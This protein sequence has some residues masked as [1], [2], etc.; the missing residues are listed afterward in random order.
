MIFDTSFI[1][2][3]MRRDENALK[4]FREVLSGDQ[5]QIITTPTLFEL[6]SG[7]AQSDK[8]YSEKE[9]IIYT[10]SHLITWHLD[11]KSAE[12]GGEIHGKLTKEGQMIDSIDSMIAGI[13]LIS[14]ERVLTRNTKHFSKIAGLKTETY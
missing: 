10:I 7:L 11:Q 6:Y 14:G 4:K 3:V 8:P 13:A 1:I 5:L 12:R 2:D 9:K